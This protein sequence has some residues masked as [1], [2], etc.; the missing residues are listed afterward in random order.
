MFFS[1][2]KKQNIVDIDKMDCNLSPSKLKQSFD[3]GDA[4]DA[5]DQS[6]SYSINDAT[7]G[8]KFV[9]CLA[10]VVGDMEFVCLKLKCIV[11]LFS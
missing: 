5:V 10:K 8:L 9:I 4:S 7:M 6:T 2:L 11:C 3:G 1:K